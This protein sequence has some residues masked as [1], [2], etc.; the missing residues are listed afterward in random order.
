MHPGSFLTAFVWGVL[1]M[2]VLL[3]IVYWVDRYEKEP[4][5]L[6][7]VALLMGAIVAPLIAVLIED[8]AN[9]RSSAFVSSTIPFSQ[10]T[11]WTPILE[12]AIRGLAILVVF[13]VE[14][15]WTSKRV[16]NTFTREFGP[17]YLPPMAAL[18]A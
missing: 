3:A 8:A 15:V 1:P 7:A 10:L 13:W 12:E 14:Y 17:V 2:V 4:L 16:R 5:K 9:I 11:P 18:G 6:I